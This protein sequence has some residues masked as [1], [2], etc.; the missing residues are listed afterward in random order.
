MGL[1]RCGICGALPGIAGLVGSGEERPHLTLLWVTLLWGQ[2]LTCRGELWGPSSEQVFAPPPHPSDIFRS[3]KLLP[4]FAK[5][6]ENIFLPLFKAT[7]NPQDHR[8]LHLFL[9]Y[10]SGMGLGQ[11]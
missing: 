4:N 7:I 3:K 2:S 8:E 9:K 11:A 5:M 10:V 6:L 1:G